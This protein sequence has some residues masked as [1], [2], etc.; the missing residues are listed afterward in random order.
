MSQISSPFENSS[1]NRV[2]LDSKSVLGD[3]SSLEES[4]RTDA[5]G[6]LAAFFSSS[7]SNI[8]LEK[9]LIPSLL[10]QLNLRLVDQS[11]AVRIQS[12]LALRNM[13]SWASGHEPCIRILFDSGIYTTTATLAARELNRICTSDLEFQSFEYLEHI[14][15]SLKNVCSATEDA[16]AQLLENTANYSF[17]T[18]I[19]PL[20]HPKIP[21]EVVD[22]VTSLLLTVTDNHPLA[23]DYLQQTEEFKVITSKACHDKD[24]NLPLILE[25]GNVLLNCVGVFMNVIVY[26]P[27]SFNLEEE[28]V[29][30]IM[31]TLNKVL[32]LHCNPP[33]AL[34]RVHRRPSGT[35]N[36]ECE[37]TPSTDG[38]PVVEVAE[39]KSALEESHSFALSLLKGAGEIVSNIAHFAKDLKEDD[40]IELVD[41]KS[42]DEDD[43]V[44]VAET[45]LKGE[46]FT[47]NTG[48]DFVRSTNRNRVLKGFWQH[49]FWEA[50]LDKLSQLSEELSLSITAASANKS[51]G[52]DETTVMIPVVV[53]RLVA[54]C[55]NLLSMLENNHYRVENMWETI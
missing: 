45:T 15:M 14:M 12:A 43:M 29:A 5:C 3:L 48:E 33:I 40:Y 9:L 37:A 36:M 8:A 46:G 16:I 25:E 53:D 4:K 35:S 55:S 38:A 30:K 50:S 24:S 13:T 2:V 49:E 34:Q 19:T 52:V 6:I 7:D 42:D 26:S 41:W 28:V 18:L 27:N 31:C 21:L 51:R 47:I 54:M 17:T 44:E 22:V 1:P 39:A 20:S 11:S 32:S 10:S 23:C